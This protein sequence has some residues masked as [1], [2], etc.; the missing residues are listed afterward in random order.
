MVNKVSS[1]GGF[2]VSRPEVETNKCCVFS[3]STHAE[4]QLRLALT[5]QLERR[6]G[7][8]QHLLIS[9]SVLFLTGSV[10]KGPNYIVGR[11][12]QI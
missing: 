6:K 9:T 12:G 11:G 2:L 8:T 10:H 5:P 4:L 7:N 3:F 1:G